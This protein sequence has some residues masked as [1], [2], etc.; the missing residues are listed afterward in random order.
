MAPIDVALQDSKWREEG[1]QFTSRQIA[2]KYG[3]DRSTLGRRWEGV[4][5]SRK[6]GYAQVGHLVADQNTTF[7][8]R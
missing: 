3:V 6:E 2:D 1:E 8:R 7:D 4:T 5:H